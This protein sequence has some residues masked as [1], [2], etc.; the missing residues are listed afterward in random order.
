MTC[1]ET[2]RIR[3][4]TAVTIILMLWSN[5]S[6]GITLTW[7]ANTEPDLAGYYIYQCSVQP[8]TKVSGTATRLATLGKVTSFNVGTPAVIKY[9]VITAYDFS[10]NESTESPVATYIPAGTP[11]PPAFIGGA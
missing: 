5:P 11:P 10:N 1:K 2:R 7:N 6:W 8:C 3:W 4:A 9:Y